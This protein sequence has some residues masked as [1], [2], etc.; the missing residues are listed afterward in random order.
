M[1]NADPGNVFTA[2]AF[3]GRGGRHRHE[4]A[5]DDARDHHVKKMSATFATKSTANFA[6]VVERTDMPRPALPWRN[7]REKGS[8]ILYSV[9]F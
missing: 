4:R 7:R 9:R 6:V 5:A 3:G 1:A 8:K 2:R